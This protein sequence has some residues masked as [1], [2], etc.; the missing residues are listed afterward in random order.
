MKPS[1]P[2][3][4]VCSAGDISMDKDKDKDQAAQST[5]EG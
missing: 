2:H 1:K 3:R 5:E 4:F